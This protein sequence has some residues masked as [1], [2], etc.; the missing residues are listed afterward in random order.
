MPCL[1]VDGAVDVSDDE[2]NT[3]LHHAVRYGGLPEV[4]LLLKHR[5]AAHVCN[6]AGDLP[7]HV[8]LRQYAPS[9]GLARVV[10]QLIS[11]RVDLQGL[12]S[13]GVPPLCHAAAAGNEA[14]VELLLKHGADPAG[15]DSHGRNGLHHV[16]AGSIEQVAAVRERDRLQPTLVQ[17]RTT[18]DNAMSALSVR[19]PRRATAD[20][21]VDAARPGS[22]FQALQEL[23]AAFAN[24][25]KTLVV[26]V[27]QRQAIWH[28]IGIYVGTLAMSATIFPVK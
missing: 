10:E 19:R 8:L 21:A 16:A 25:I 22:L 2:C 6:S 14:V 28:S 11:K 23:S 27:I 18:T 15:A 13:T 17:H 1:P 4:S 12:D 24:I 9:P 3:L 5:A 26:C 7:L 20:R